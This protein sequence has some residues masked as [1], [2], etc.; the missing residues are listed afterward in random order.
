MRPWDR[1]WGRCRFLTVRPARHASSGWTHDPPERIFRPDQCSAQSGQ[2]TDGGRLPLR[3]WP[4]V[5]FQGGDATADICK[6]LMP[7]SSLSAP[8]CRYH[9]GRQRTRPIVAHCNA[10]SGSLGKATSLTRCTAHTCILA[11]CKSRNMD[12]SCTMH[13]NMGNMHRLGKLLLR[14][15]INTYTSIKKSVCLQTRLILR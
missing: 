7:L 3:R 15:S 1:H 5:A 10:P 9:V 11:F 14:L 4:A 13:L 8:C 6:R 2:G 12:M